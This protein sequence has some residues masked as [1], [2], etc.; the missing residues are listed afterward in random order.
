M[1][2][3]QN[4]KSQPPTLRLQSTFKSTTRLQ[5]NNDSGGHSSPCPQELTATAS[6]RR[7]KTG[8]G[9]A[10]VIHAEL[11]KKMPTPLSVMWMGRLGPR[12]PG[13]PSGSPPWR[14]LWQVLWL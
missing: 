14:L 13:R 10:K 11:T 4:Y 3:K 6:A 2:I 5:C 12:G 9:R 8:G 1:D 7:G